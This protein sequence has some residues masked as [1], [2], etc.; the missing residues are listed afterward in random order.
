LKAKK[1]TNLVKN[2]AVIIAL[3][4]I[5][6]SLV[7]IYF[8]NYDYESAYATGSSAPAH[9]ALIS[10]AAEFV[11]EGLDKPDERIMAYSVLTEIE[12]DYEETSTN[13]GIECYEESYTKCYFGQ[14]NSDNTEN[15]M[16][17]ACNTPVYSTTGYDL[18]CFC[19]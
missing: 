6:V 10:Y 12:A 4:I 7:L 17:I 9:P 5:V 14:I 15:M 2:I 11:Q 19:E 1:R 18:K 16:T 3:L 8:Y 13:C